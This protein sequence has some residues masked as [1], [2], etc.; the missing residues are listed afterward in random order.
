MTRT[1]TLPNGRTVKVPQCI[2]RIDIEHKHTHGWQ[3]RRNGTKFFS[4]GTD[5]PHASLTNACHELH[6]RSKVL[7][8]RLDGFHS[9]V[10][11]LAGTGGLENK[12]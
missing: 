9:T 4:D 8:L 3:V 7:P 10:A 11:R 12:W 5:G 2:Q 6:A 1:V